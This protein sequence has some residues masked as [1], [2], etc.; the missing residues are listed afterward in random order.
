MGVLLLAIETGRFRSIPLEE[1]LCVLCDLNVI[2]GEKHFLCNCKLYEDIR[3]IMYDN[4]RQKYQL[5]STLNVN[6]KFHFLVMPVNGK[7]WVFICSVH[8]KE[9]IVYY[10]NL[11]E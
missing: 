2:E 5:F 6:E 1:R 8:G 7:K 4:V 11:D 9:E 10:M 3:Q